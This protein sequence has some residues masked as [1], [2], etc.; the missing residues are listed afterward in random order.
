MIDLIYLAHNRLEF[1]KASLANLIANTDWDQVSRLLIYDD[2]STDG[3][4]EYLQSVE[5]PARPEVQ[6]C[7]GTFGSPVA[8]MNHH[9]QAGGEE[10]FAKIDSDT[11]VP[12]GWLEECLPV[13]D[14]LDLL[15]IEARLCVDEV[16]PCPW[17]RPQGFRAW[18]SFVPASFIGGIGLMRRPAFRHPLSG[19][20]SLPIPNGRF[21]FTSWQ[22]RHNCQRIEGDGWLRIG[23]LNP[24]MPTFLLDRLPREPWSSLSREYVDK[25]WQRA[26]PP[27]DESYSDQ[28]SWWCE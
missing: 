27:Y 18:R 28:W 15:G 6:L 5:Y 8:I 3:T 7:F 26:W 17:E 19:E 2:N 22:E 23:W 12:L 9:I 21:G 1:T 24:S 11:M 4:R 14:R 20:L 10:L 13:V 16:T 25:G